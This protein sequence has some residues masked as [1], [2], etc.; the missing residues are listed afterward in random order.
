[1]RI[2]KQHRGNGVECRGDGVIY[3][4]NKKT[5]HDVGFEIFS[6]VAK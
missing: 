4:E 6:A 5:I 3:G 1:M 2:T